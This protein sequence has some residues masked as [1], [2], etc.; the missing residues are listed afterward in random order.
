MSII[1]CWIKPGILG[2]WDSPNPSTNA[3]WCMAEIQR[4][5]PNWSIRSHEEVEMKAL[6]ATMK[7]V[8][9]ICEGDPD[10]QKADSFDSKIRSIDEI[11]KLLS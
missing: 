3:A 11:K 9:G 10:L 7:C 5:F 4:L 1:S 6:K 8:E 2:E